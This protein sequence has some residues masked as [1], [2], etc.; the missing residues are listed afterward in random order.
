M[1]ACTEN[2]NQTQGVQNEAPHATAH[3]TSQ[4][5]NTWMLKQFRYVSYVLLAAAFLIVADVVSRFAFQPD[6]YESP[7]RSWAYWAVRGINEQKQ[8]P[9]V[10]ILG[11]SLVLAAVHDGDATYYNKKIDAVL[12]HNSGYLEKQLA[13]RLGAPVKTASLAIGGQMA[14]D[15]YALTTN[16]LV[17]EKKPKAI[18]WGIAPR[19]FVDSTFTEPRNSETIHFLN[20]V[21]G[22]QV[23]DGRFNLWNNLEYYV[24]FVSD[25]YT[26]RGSFVCVQQKGIKSLLTCLGIGDDLEVIGAPQELQLIAMHELPEDNGLGA[27][28]VHPYTASNQV[29]TDNSAEYRMRYTPFKPQVLETQLAYLDKLLSYARDNGIAVTLVNMPLTKENLSILPTGVYEKYLAGVTQ[30]ARAQGADM[31]DLNDPK[32]FHKEDFSDYVHLNGLGAAKLL[33]LVAQRVVARSRTALLSGST[34]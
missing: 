19:D 1:A 31:L 29:W 9:D 7:N 15:A 22:K 4:A 8:A 33:D 14:S 30:A 10:A 2:K 17:G 21:A 24:A 20:R 34:Q 13:Q 5:P 3:E 11:S 26:K 23:L 25:I 12:H 6:R 32:L 28:N 27:W 18:V 16:I